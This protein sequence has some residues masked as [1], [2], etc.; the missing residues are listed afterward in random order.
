MRIVIRA[1]GFEL[2]DAL[3]DQVERRVRLAL[4][5]SADCLDGVTVRITQRVV[6]AEGD[7]RYIC[8]VAITPVRLQ[9]EEKHD[10]LDTAIDRAIDR[11]VR[12]VVPSPI[13]NPPPK[14]GKWSRGAPR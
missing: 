2:T 1:K 9:V 6:P 3:R 13:R 11:A 14:G 7:A 10:R 12:L 8:E 4:A 5:R